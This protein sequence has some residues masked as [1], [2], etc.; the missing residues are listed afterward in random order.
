[1]KMLYVD[2]SHTL[3][4]ETILHGIFHYHKEQSQTGM[5]SKLH[6]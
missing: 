1:M 6:S 4:K 3:L 2:Y 5:I